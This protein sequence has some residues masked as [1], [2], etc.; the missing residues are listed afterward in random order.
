MPKRNDGAVRLVGWGD[1]H[2]RPRP[3]TRPGGWRGEVVIG[4]ARVVAAS[5]SAGRACRVPW[6]PGAVGSAS[7]GRRAGGGSRVEGARA[8]A[9]GVAVSGEALAQLVAFVGDLG[10]LVFEFDDAADRG[11]AH[12]FAHQC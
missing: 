1:R 3:V 2:C 11:Q 12:A 10:E 6:T 5:N 9:A 8:V 7:L 4:A